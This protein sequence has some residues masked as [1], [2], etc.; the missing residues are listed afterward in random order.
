MHKMFMKIGS[1]KIL[2]VINTILLLFLSVA[3][4]IDSHYISSILCILYVLL[5]IATIKKFLVI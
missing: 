5:S 4:L 3:S 1:M 2:Y